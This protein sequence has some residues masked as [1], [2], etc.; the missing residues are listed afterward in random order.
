MT[1]SHHLRNRA[2]AASDHLTSE[3]IHEVANMSENRPNNGL[4]TVHDATHNLLR[5][6]GLTTIFG[7]PGSTEQPFLKNFPGDFQ[8]VLGLQEASCWI[9]NAEHDGAWS[10]PCYQPKN[11]P[12]D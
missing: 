1:T 11:E 10:Y 7:N 4:M 3:R 2:P 5:K 12:V 6:L 8:Y 9:V